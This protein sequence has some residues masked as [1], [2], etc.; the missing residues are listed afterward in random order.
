MSKLW[1]VCDTFY[2][3]TRIMFLSETGD[4]VQE[5]GLPSSDFLNSQFKE[6]RLLKLF[7]SVNNFC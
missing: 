1:L 6:G 3:I 5:R 4:R 7:D 2:L